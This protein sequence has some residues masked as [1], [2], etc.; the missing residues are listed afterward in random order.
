MTAAPVAFRGACPHCGAAL[1]FLIGSSRSAVCEYCHTLVARRGP[2][3]EELGRWPTSFRPGHRSSSAIS[4]SSITSRSA[5]SA[6]S[7]TSG[8]RAS[9][10]SGTSPWTT[11]AGAGSPKRKDATTS[12]SAPGHAASSSRGG[13]A[14]R[15][16]HPR[17][18]QACRHGYQAGQDRHRCRRAP[19]RG[20]ARV[21]AAH[22][23]PRRTARKLRHDR[24]RRSH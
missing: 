7:N 8:S 10:T 2:A 22:R 3:Y 6:D 20:E 15:D 24:L 17:L 19:R 9:G 16:R 12:C 23:G 21:N 14:G 4:V 18:G 11:G 5:W 1:S 13:Q